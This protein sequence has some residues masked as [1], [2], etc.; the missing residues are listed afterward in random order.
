MLQSIKGFFTKV[1]PDAFD[2]E[3]ANVAKNRLKLVLVND[4]VKITPEEIELLKQDLLE[5]IC[6]Y[7][8]IDKEDLEVFLTQKNKTTSLVVDIPVR[9]RKKE[10]TAS[11]V[12][13]ATRKTTKRIK[14]Q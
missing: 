13:T 1:F 4:R 7:I 2:D 10:A 11:L 8:E 6:R 9:S 14:K 5:V 12:K 3:S